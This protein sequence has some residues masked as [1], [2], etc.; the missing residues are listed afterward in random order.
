[1]SGVDSGIVPDGRLPTCSIST[2]SA[3]PR[4]RAPFSSASPLCIAALNAASIRFR[5]SGLSERM[6]TSI[7]T[8][9]GIELT[10]VPPP[11]TPTL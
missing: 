10:E 3:G 7:I 11:I 2:S 1:M 9:N 4:R 6:S 5:L 8:S